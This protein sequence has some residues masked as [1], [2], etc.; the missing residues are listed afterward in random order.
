MTDFMKE[1]MNLENFISENILALIKRKGQISN[2]RIEEDQINL[3]S[4]V[5]MYCFNIFEAVEAFIK[6]HPSDYKELL[7]GEFDVIKNIRLPLFAILDLAFSM[8]NNT[9]LLMDQKDV[10]KATALIDMAREFKFSEA[11][12]KTWH[13]NSK[14]AKYTGADVSF[15]FLTNRRIS[16][17]NQ[18][19]GEYVPYHHNTIDTFNDLLLGTAVDI[20]EGEQLNIEDAE[21]LDYDFSKYPDI[22]CGEIPYAHIMNTTYERGTWAVKTQKTHKVIIF[23]EQ[24]TLLEQKYAKLQRLISEKKR[25]ETVVA[26]EKN[27]FP[28]YQDRSMKEFALTPNISWNASEETQNMAKSLERIFYKIKEVCD[29]TDKSLEEVLQDAKLVRRFAGLATFVSVPAHLYKKDLIRQ[30]LIIYENASSL[31]KAMFAE[32]HLQKDTLEERLSLLSIADLDNVLKKSRGKLFGIRHLVRTVSN[33][34]V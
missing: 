31:S 26:L 17:K 6:V 27:V 19:N 23:E 28:Y 30:L 18:R 3:S 4:S 34:E 9:K 20:P 24:E 16:P 8:A 14:I 12:D 11:F 29:E 7:S 2:M 32:A 15:G 5:V 10:K 25:Q 33:Q 22:W 1:R 13:I 21:L